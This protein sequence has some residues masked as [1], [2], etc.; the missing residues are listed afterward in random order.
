M[1]YNILINDKDK[2][3]SVTLEVKGFGT[4]LG[5]DSD[6]FKFLDEHSDEKVMIRMNSY[7]CK[8]KYEEVESYK[9]TGYYYR[10]YTKKSEY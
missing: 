7:T 8:T 9:Y 4:M 2:R 1:R 3:C 5:H 10:I 6:V